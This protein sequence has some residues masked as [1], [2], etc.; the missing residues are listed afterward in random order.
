LIEIFSGGLPTADIGERAC[1]KVTNLFDTRKMVQSIEEAYRQILLS[2]R[3]LKA[4]KRAARA[5][6]IPPPNP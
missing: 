1:E 4:Q 2:T 3:V 6:E 5:P